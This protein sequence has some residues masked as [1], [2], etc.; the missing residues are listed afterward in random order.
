MDAGL[1][2][3]IET[4]TGHGASALFAGS[5]GYAAYGFLATLTVQPQLGLCAVGAGVVAFLPCSRALG[6]GRRGAGFVLPDFALRDFEFAEAGDELLLTDADRLTAADELV[7]TDADRLTAADEL[8]LTDADR[9]MPA[10]E[11]VLSQADRLDAAAPLVLD[12]ILAAI[13]PESRVVRL[14]D[15]KAMPT[16]PPTPGQLQSRIADHL[17]DGAPRFAPSDASQA[18]SAALAE[19]RRSLR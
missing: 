10:D 3:R 6:A 9:L 2:E 16:P 8:V 4:G 1:I 13:G 14:F 19:L 18:L 12:D 17:G 15:R 11:L 5:V 7:L